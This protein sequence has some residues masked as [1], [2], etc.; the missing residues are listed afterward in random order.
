MERT[1]NQILDIL[2]STYGFDEILKNSELKK[3]HK[4]LTDI[5]F[6]YSHGG[7]VG[8]KNA[9]DVINRILKYKLAV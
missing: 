5:K 9:D 2:T 6:R 8:I 1:V 3:I 4:K 7:I